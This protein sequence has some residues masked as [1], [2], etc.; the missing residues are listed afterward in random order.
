MNEGDRN[1]LA[2]SF[3]ATSKFKGNDLFNA[4][5]TFTSHAENHGVLVLRTF[6][7]NK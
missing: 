4:F 3:L 5:C 6:V 7:S 2:F 1:F